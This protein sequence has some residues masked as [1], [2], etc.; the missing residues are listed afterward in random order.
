MRRDVK[1]TMSKPI[2]EGQKRI[3]RSIRTIKLLEISESNYDARKMGNRSGEL[4]IPGS[5]WEDPG[6]PLVFPR[7]DRDRERGRDRQVKEYT[8]YIG[9]IAVLNLQEIHRPDHGLHRHKNVLVHEFDESSLIL[10]RVAG[11]VDDPHLL[12]EGGFARLAGTWQS[13]HPRLV[14]RLATRVR[15]AIRFPDFPYSAER[16]RGFPNRQSS[17]TRNGTGGTRN[18]GYESRSTC[19]AF[20]TAWALTARRRE[21]RQELLGK[22]FQKNSRREMRSIV[23]ALEGALSASHLA[24]LALDAPPE[25]RTRHRAISSWSAPEKNGGGQQHGSR[26][27]ARSDRV[28]GARRAATVLSSAFAKS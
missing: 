23:A 22:A 5:S 9:G 25:H 8:H 13:F 27:V 4:T 7:R 28:G 20:E 15:Y 11:T 18:N 2:N 14:A 16:P 26:T 6:I 12:D 19:P 17:G 3:S 24:A 1:L 21:K 10:V